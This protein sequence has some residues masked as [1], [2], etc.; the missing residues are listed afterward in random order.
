MDWARVRRA[1][2]RERCSP[3]EIDTGCLR[4]A[5]I[6]GL[7]FFFVRIFGLDGFMVTGSDFNSAMVLGSA[8]SVLDGTCWQADKKRQDKIVRF[9]TVP[10]RLR[11]L[12]DILFK[13]V[14]M[15]CRQKDSGKFQF[16]LA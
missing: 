5:G 9:M 13:I 3:I 10:F 12:C 2:L 16:M 14:K 4:E 15:F 11:K 1:E 8:K 6:A 7:I